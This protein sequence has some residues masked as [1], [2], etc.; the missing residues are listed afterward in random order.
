MG[1]VEE[2]NQQFN[3]LMF[4]NWRRLELLDWIEFADVWQTIGETIRTDVWL[5]RW[6][7]ADSVDD[8]YRLD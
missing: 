1:I 7:P 5:F 8:R 2:G 6:N 3:N 4:K